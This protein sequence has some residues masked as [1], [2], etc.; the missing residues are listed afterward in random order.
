[1]KR[2]KPN[3]LSNDDE[4]FRYH[5]RNLHFVC[6]K[7]RKMFNQPPSHRRLDRPHKAVQA[8]CP[9]CGMEMTNAG[10]NFKPP[11][12]NNIKQWRKVE[13]LLQRG[14]KWDYTV[15]TRE[16]TQGL[17][18]GAVR[19]WCTNRVFNDPRA[20]TLREAKEDYPPRG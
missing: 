9:E 10:H 19:G 16:I 2:K 13:L 1:M 17:P 15:E 5:S 3:R 12:R 18:E 7:C 20:K 14:Y 8:S 6:L 11:R 4:L